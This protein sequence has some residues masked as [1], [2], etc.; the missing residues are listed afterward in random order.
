MRPTTRIMSASS[1]LLLWLLALLLPVLPVQASQL[2]FDVTSTRMNYHSMVGAVGQHT[3]AGWMNAVGVHPAYAWIP[4]QLDSTGASTVTLNGTGGNLNLSVDLKGIVYG[5]IPAG[6]TNAPAPAGLAGSAL[7]SVQG[8]SFAVYGGPAQSYASQ[9]YQRSGSD[10]HTPFT[11]MRPIFAVNTDELITALQGLPS[12]T[13]TGT[14][15][16]SYRYRVQYQ[17]GGTWSYEVR[18]IPLTVQVKYV[19]RALERITVTGT[20]A[21][22]PVY[23]EGTT[24]VTGQTSWNVIASGMMPAGIHMRFQQP[25]KRFA[26][27][28]SGAAADAPDIPYNLKINNTNSEMGTGDPQIL[29]TNGALTSGADQVI[30]KPVSGVEQIGFSLDADF[31]S[32][33]VPGGEY[34]DQFTVM[35]EVVIE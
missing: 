18:S 26:M 5:G 10:A 1:P 22:T 16:M 11:M 12:G 35:F 21:F 15:P 23:T 8:N 9:M 32:G 20:G 7:A 4:G 24:E 3:T 31:A 13:Y 28:K 25:D 2:Y 33:F 29:I 27:T 19:A 6:F 17:Q 30:I 14:L 34:T